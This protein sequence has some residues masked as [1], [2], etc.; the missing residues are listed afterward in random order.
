MPSSWHPNCCTGQGLLLSTFKSSSDPFS[1][2]RR[3]PSTSPHTPFRIPWDSAASTETTGS[4]PPWRRATSPA[5]ATSSPPMT[6]STSTPATS[7]AA[8]PVRAAPA[9]HSVHCLDKKNQ[10][11]PRASEHQHQ[12][13]PKPAAK[14]QL[15]A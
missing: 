15:E 9:Q 10:I 8:R 13:D 1:R 11:E 12:P 7:P 3:P 2:P 14:P 6:T 5:Q 4:T